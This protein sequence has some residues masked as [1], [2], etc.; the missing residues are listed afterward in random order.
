MSNHTKAIRNAIDRQPVIPV[1]R[2]DIEISGEWRTI[3]AFDDYRPAQILARDLN[4]NGI[5]AMISCACGSYE[6]GAC[7]LCCVR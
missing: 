4:S 7:E 2:L 6:F 1:C 5:P 3:K